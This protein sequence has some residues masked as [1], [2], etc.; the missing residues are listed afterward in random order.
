MTFPRQEYWSGLLFP[1]PGGL[2]HPA[3]EAASPAG[4]FFTTEPPGK[5][6]FIYLF[7]LGCAGSSLLCVG[8]SL[9]AQVG[10]TLNLQ[11]MG[12]SLR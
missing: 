10:A 6:L 1:P 9:V 11:C 12:F 3:V 5:P 2:P 4:E 7:I 8:F